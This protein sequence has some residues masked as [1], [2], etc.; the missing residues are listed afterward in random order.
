MP[1]DAFKSIFNDGFDNQIPDGTDGNQA[2]YGIFYKDELGR[3]RRIT[4]AEGNEISYNPETVTRNLIANE[5]PAEFIR[6]YQ[7]QF[8]KGILIRKGDPEYEFFNRFRELLPTGANAQLVI[9]LVD[10][11]QETPGTGGRFNYK[12]IQFAVTATI[13]TGNETDGLLDL[14]FGQASDIVSGIAS[15]E[16]FTETNRH[17]VFIP[18]TSITPA[19]MNLSDSVATLALGEEK[20]IAVGMEPMGCLDGFEIVRTGGAGHDE[21]VCGAR[22]VRNS[23]II[24]GKEPGETKV[25]L[26]SLAENGPSETIAVKVGAAS[27]STGSGVAVPSGGTLAPARA[28]VKASAE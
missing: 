23:V 20:W 25:T 3:F 26:R 11:R 1:T 18:S 4:Q 2:Q 22:I 19:M 17:P 8:S 12:A 14:S 10:F 27:Q 28:P 9:M 7:L 16:S 15:S 21:R 13:N 5:N 6:R 24:T